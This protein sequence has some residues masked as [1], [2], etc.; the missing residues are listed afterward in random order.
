MTNNL[1]DDEPIFPISS[2]ALLLKISVHTLRM[3]ER[4]GLFIP[5][6]KESNQRLYSKR[7]LERIECIRRAIN[8]MKV[9]INGI[10]T[11][12]SLIPCWD[13]VKCSETDRANCEAYKE[14]SKPCWTYKHKNNI[15]EKLNCR[16]CSVYLNF[17]K[18]DHI[19]DAIKL[20]TVNK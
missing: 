6:K 8:E 20:I 7:D 2:A 4:E 12:Y 17:T 15:C 1:K 3:Y 18:C 19:K 10:K 16:E 13:I 9:S 14:H 11:M 5:Y